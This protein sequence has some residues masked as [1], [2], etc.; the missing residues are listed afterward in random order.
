MAKMLSTQM[1]AIFGILILSSSIEA[2]D[3]VT[4]SGRLACNPTKLCGEYDRKIW[5]QKREHV[6]KFV[7]LINEQRNFEGYTE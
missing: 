3:A 7:E 1:F 2:H 6:K 5:L 4:S